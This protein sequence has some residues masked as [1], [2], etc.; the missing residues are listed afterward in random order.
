MG[1][2]ETKDSSKLAIISDIHG[3]SPALHSVLDDI[4]HEQCAKVFMLGDIINGVDPNGCVQMLRS[5]SAQNRVDLECI[6]GN[7][8]SYLTTPDR[9]L[10]MKQIDA[11]RVEILKEMQWYEDRL[12]GPDLY[13]IKSLPDTMRWNNAYLVHD[14]PM[15]R[16]AVQSHTDIPPLYRE[17][18]YHGRGIT[19]D[20]A[21]S[22]WTGLIEYMH[23]DGVTRVFSG[24]THAPFCREFDNLLVCNVGSAGMPLDGDPR[25]SWVMVDGSKSEIQ[26]VSIRRVDYDIAS[27]LHLIDH[28]SDYPKFQNTDFQEA[29][30]K[31]FLHGHH[32]RDYMPNDNR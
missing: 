9:D 22:D 5:W 30:K 2:I 20:M 28:T 10:L 17:L 4:H 16:L 13:W 29:Y 19:Q 26:P 32:W 31:M 27:L 8:E 25:P 23:R 1:N 14:S 18:Y 12:S 3:N 24:H 11:Y 6:K 15:D 21:E 7:A